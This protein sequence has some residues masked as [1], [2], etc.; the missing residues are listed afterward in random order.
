MRVSFE[1]S[2][3]LLRLRLRLRRWQLLAGWFYGKF[4]KVSSL[5]RGR[6]SMR[7]AFSWTCCSVRLGGAAS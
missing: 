2:L 5:R 3:L 7:V 6:R 1:M 4:V